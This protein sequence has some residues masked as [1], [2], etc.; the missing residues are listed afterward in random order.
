M[1]LFSLFEDVKD[2][3]KLKSYMKKAKN[4]DAKSQY[5]VGMAYYSGYY[6]GVP[7]EKNLDEALKWIRMSAEQDYA[8]AQ[9]QLGR[10]YGLGHGVAKDFSESAKWHQKASKTYKKEGN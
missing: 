4:G 1:R 2:V 7:I 5:T 10:M 8:P 9:G 3:F 6:E